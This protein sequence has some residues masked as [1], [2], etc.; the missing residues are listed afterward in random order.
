[1]TLK[2]RFEKDEIPKDVRNAVQPS[3]VRVQYVP[4]TA[5]GSRLAAIRLFRKD[6][7]NHFASQTLDDDELAVF[8]SKGFAAT[9]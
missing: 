5:D 3:Y 1:M 8:V 9:E 4:G 6:G 7:T 2:F